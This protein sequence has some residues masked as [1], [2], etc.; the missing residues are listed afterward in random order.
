[1]K[2]SSPAPGD[3]EAR[4]RDPL[5]VLTLVSV[6]VVARLNGLSAWWLNPD[7]G[8]YY[9]ILT[10]ADFAGFW[11]EVTAN[12][13]P[14]LY[15]LILRGLG[16]LTWDFYW[17]RLFSVVC[18]VVAVVVMWAAAREA[19]GRG[20]RG[21]IAG[22]TAGLLVALAPGAIEMSQVM[23][24]Y[25]LQLTLVGTSLW[26]LL[27]YR[28]SEGMR[29][30]AI[31]AVAIS[32]ALLT[33]YSSMLALGAIGI[34][35]AW[36]GLDR[37]LRERHWLKLAAAQTAPALVVA[38]LYF[39]HIRPL[40]GSALADDALDG[41]LSFY[42][43]ESVSSAWLAFLGFQHLLADA[44]LRGPMALL[45]IGALALAVAKDPRS[46]GVVGLGAVAMGVIAAALGAYPLGST[47]H[48]MWLVAFVVPPIG[49]LA[50][51][52]SEA[53]QQVRTGGLAVV[54]LLLAAGGP[55][56]DLF[57]APDAPWAPSD[58][59]LTQANL[60]QMVGAL[61]PAEGPPLLV[62]SAQTFYLFLPF[63]AQERE[64]AV[65][66][67]DSTA[68]HFE[69]GSRRILASSAWDFSTRADVPGTRS[70]GDFLDGAEASFPEIG[71]AGE[72]DAT[73]LVGGWRPPFVGEI[74]TLAEQH[75]FLRAG[76]YVPGFF[77][78]IV[79]VPSLR[80]ALGRRD[81]GEVLP[82]RG[83]P[84]LGR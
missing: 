55:V 82:Q 44:W 68:F 13:H 10:R 69:Y 24:P 3:F 56:G 33:H 76:N 12:A 25:M 70:L 34:Y 73:L 7:E 19:M 17:L 79:D 9:S 36:D 26:M 8:I 38:G 72:L 49:M 60:T 59:V 46:L 78:F 31:Y 21:A 39:I 62:M 14:P 48:S 30:L 20:R 29:E 80:R 58:L 40:A 16:S 54:A 50:A 6:A 35:V 81:S 84:V 61:D 66:S 53:R 64:S 11:A 71:L 4:Y 65:F 32:A 75:D 45:I 47:R 2:P 77:G 28:E 15:Y 22:F 1:M 18:G 42:M 63:Y 57:G 83:E 27:R 52:L 41:W 5:L 67:A 74:S 23:R 43:I 51:K 37:G